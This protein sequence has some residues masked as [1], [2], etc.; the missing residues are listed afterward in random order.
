MSEAP[1]LPLAAGAVVSGAAFTVVGGSV[2]VVVVVVVLVVVVGGVTVCRTRW[3][4]SG[5]CSWTYG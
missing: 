3:T 5:K 4:R 1:K 2:V